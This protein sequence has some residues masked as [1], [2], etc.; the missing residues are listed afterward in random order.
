MRRTNV[1]KTKAWAMFLDR[2]YLAYN[3]KIIYRDTNIIDL[4]EELN[5][6]PI[7]DIEDKIKYLITILNTLTNKDHPL[8]VFMF[9]GCDSIKSNIYYKFKY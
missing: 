1:L 4:V 3:K 6:E 9:F 7:T 2:V 8:L 5:I